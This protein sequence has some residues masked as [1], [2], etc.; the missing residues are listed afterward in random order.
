MHR[1]LVTLFHGCTKDVRN[2]EQVAEHLDFC[3]STSAKAHEAAQH[4]AST[5]LTKEFICNECGLGHSSKS[6]LKFPHEE[7]RC[8][9]SSDEE[10][11][12]AIGKRISLSS[13][14]LT[15]SNLPDKPWLAL[16]M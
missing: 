13:S 6:A 3:K 12:V 11:V 2:D 9:A 8:E 4:Y 10:D 14:L 16:R 5:A 7:L 1:A 15:P